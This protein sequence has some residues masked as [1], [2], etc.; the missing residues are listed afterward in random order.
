MF[1]IGKDIPRDKGPR[2]IKELMVAN[3]A[4][5]GHYLRPRVVPLTPSNRL[6][7]R[8]LARSGIGIRALNTA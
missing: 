3:H 7:G 4:I 2:F 1:V 6:Q 5:L 8:A